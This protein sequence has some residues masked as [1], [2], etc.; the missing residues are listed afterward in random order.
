ME[1]QEVENL[2]E[3]EQEALKRILEQENGEDV[4]RIRDNI[5]AKIEVELEDEVCTVPAAITHAWSAS[6]H[7]IEPLHRAIASNHC[8]IKQSSSGQ[9]PSSA[10]RV[11]TCNNWASVLVQSAKNSSIEPQKRRILLISTVIPC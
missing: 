6:N 10:N 9:P 7:C 4:R 11:K 2:L 1:Y 3:E 5:R 8:S